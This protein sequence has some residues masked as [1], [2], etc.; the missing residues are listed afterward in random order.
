M[1][2]ENQPGSVMTPSAVIAYTHM[3]IYIEISGY[4]VSSDGVNPMGDLEI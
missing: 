1:I 4:V 3:G 2:V